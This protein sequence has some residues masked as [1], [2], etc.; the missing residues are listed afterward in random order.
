MVRLTELQGEDWC[1][2]VSGKVLVAMKNHHLLPYPTP[3]AF[4]NSSPGLEPKA[5]TLGTP[6]E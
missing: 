3:K 6:I 1:K 5:T 4:A 2:Y